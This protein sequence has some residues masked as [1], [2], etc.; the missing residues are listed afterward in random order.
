MTGSP[1]F[2]LR[3]TLRHIKAT[4]LGAI[5]A[6]LRL[7]IL[8]GSKYAR[9]AIPLDYAPLWTTASVGAFHNLR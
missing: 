8:P 9:V 2:A 6:A 5:P 3:T 1:A 4:L 7:E